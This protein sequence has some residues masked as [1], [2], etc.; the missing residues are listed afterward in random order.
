MWNKYGKIRNENI[1]LTYA[2]YHTSMILHYCLCAN[3]VLCMCL[4][5]SF[6]KI[7]CWSGPITSLNRNRSGICIWLCKHN[8]FILLLTTDDLCTISH[9][10][11]TLIQL[12]TSFWRIE[13]PMSHKHALKQTTATLFKQSKP[14][15]I[16]NEQKLFKLMYLE[17]L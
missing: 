2:R 14:A 16:L 11:D 7:P 13:S 8:C 1:C 10:E 17:E 12:V 6:F 5:C 4:L 9:K 15:V 3:I